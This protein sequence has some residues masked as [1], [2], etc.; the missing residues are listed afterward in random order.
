MGSSGLNIKLKCSSPQKTN[1]SEKCIANAIKIKYDFNQRDPK[2]FGGKYF[3][4]N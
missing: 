2:R 1:C 4:D 3:D